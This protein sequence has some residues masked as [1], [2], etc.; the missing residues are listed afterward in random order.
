[1]AQVGNAFDTYEATS[2]REQLSNII[3]NI[4]PTSTPLL[5]AAG[6]NSIRNVV[7]DWQTEVIPSAVGTGQLEGFELSRAATTP[8]VRATN[9][10]MIQSRDSTV[11]GSQQASDPAGVKSQIA[12]F[13]ALNAKALKRDIETAISGNYAKAG[14]NVTTARAT[15]SFEAWISTNTSRGSGGA[16]GSTSAAAT[17]GTKRDL[18]EALLKGVLETGFGSGAD[19][20]LAICGPYNKTVISGFTG[21]SSARQIIDA[22]TVEASVSLYASDF[23]E[24]KIVPSN[25]SRERSLLLVDPEYIAVSYLRDFESIDIATVGDAITKLLVVEFGLQMSNEAAHGI[26]ADIN[27]S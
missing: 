7:F 8:T 24:L 2:D 14:G 22:T 18:T 10:A 12:H 1:M 3:Y 9:V 5:S 15:R 11:S 19:M 27:V 23:G 6:R 17:D 21:R 16:D 25:F 26:V 13:M 20:S 4:S